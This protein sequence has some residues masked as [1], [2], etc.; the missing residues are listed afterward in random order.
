M[1]ENCTSEKNQF[2]LLQTEW[3]VDRQVH[4]IKTKALKM[5]AL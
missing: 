3:E 2:G 1:L 4:E 5:R